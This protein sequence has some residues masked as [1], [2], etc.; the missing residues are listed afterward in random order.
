MT[1]RNKFLK[2]LL[3]TVAILT[4]STIAAQESEDPWL[5]LEEIDGITSESDQIKTVDSVLRY[6][7]YIS[8][9]EKKNANAQNRRTC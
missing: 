5:F 2:V 1:S 6:R 8:V 7:V 9:L 4:T 3:I